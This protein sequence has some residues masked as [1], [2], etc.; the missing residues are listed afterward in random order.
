M[1]YAFRVLI[2]AAWGLACLSPAMPALADC[3]DGLSCTVIIRPVA[4][5]TMDKATSSSGKIRC[6]LGNLEGGIAVSAIDLESIRLL[7]VVPILDGSAKI[8]NHGDFDGHV[9]D[10]SFDRQASLLALG[11]TVP[12][13]YPVHVTGH[14]LDGRAF[15]GETTVKVPPPPALDCDCSTI[16]DCNG[17]G[18]IDVA[19]VVRLIDYAFR[20]GAP[21]PVDDYCPVLNH[22]DVNCDMKINLIDVVL[23]VRYVLYQPA[24]PL[25]DPCTG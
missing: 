2:I 11:A 14:L 8:H 22:G 24:P 9:L 15:C 21:L 23:L 5:Q 12:G 19:D 18:V 16:G 13:I 17:D 20:A 4:W 10:I 1:K 3:P 7:G 25:C 6:L